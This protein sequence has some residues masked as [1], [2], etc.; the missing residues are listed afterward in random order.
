MKRMTLARVTLTA[1]LAGF[2]GLMAASAV[3]AEPKTISIP[4]ITFSAQ[5]G[6]FDVPGPVSTV[7]VEAGK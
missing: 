5:G 7:V 3:A 6:D 4:A 2:V 1:A